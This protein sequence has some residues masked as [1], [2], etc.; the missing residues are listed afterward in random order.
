MPFN[1]E[2]FKNFQA[3]L[4][5]IQ[6]LPGWNSGIM[7][8]AGPVMGNPV[9]N[10]G[11]YKPNMNPANT[12]DQIL[13]FAPAIWR[14]AELGSVASGEGIDNPFGWDPSL[15]GDRKYWKSTDKLPGT[16]MTVAQ[17][18]KQ[19]SDYNWPSYSSTAGKPNFF[20]AALSSPGIAIPLGLAAAGG[21][22][23]LPGTGGAGTATSAPGWT[24][25][26]DLAGGGAL[27]GMGPAAAATG[28]GTGTLTTGGVPLSGGSN[29]ADLVGS[30]WA[31]GAATGPVGG[32]L[33]TTAGGLTAANT[34]AAG[35][36]GI[37]KGLG[38]ILSN[39][40]GMSPGTS[41]LVGTVGQGLLG[42][43]ESNSTSSDL[44]DVANQLRADRGPALS[45][46]NTALANPNT[47]YNSAPA[48][49][50]LDAA[51]RKLSMSGNPAVNPG[52]L[53]KAAVYNLGGYNDYLRS[54][55]GP[56]FGTA[57]TEASVGQN[58]ANAGN[59]FY[60]VL[61]YGLNT[62]TQPKSASLEDLLAKFAPSLTVGGTNWG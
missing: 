20:K 1:D 40:T 62:L 17:Y 53:S 32:M 58:A 60:D 51:L 10:F 31:T 24:S 43:L 21:A 55:A 9:K 23:L 38:S 16:D 27:E 3:V 11:K 59:S 25:G 19:L 12:T 2:S 35:T 45:A 6:A 22:G 47:F 44:K 14:N 46:F 48:M 61:G 39:I 26:F 52:A 30:D 5:Q 37:G 13:E 50:A 33:P 8:N 49:G 34:A 41:N 28:A 7:P 42:L 29:L 57:S 36:K 54:L 18:E 56:A 4:P 15:Y